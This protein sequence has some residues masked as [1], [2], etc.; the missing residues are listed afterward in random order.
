MG[1]VSVVIIRFPPAGNKITN[2]SVID[3]FAIIAG[4]T[5]NIEG[6]ALRNIDG[7]TITRTSLVLQMQGYLSHLKGVVE[8]DS[9]GALR[10]VVLE[11]LIV[12]RESEGNSKLTSA[13][14]TAAGRMIFARPR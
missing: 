5:I 2:K 6:N 11:N 12:R 8:L 13:L 7:A 3:G 4:E 14:Q 1:S 9:K 10:I